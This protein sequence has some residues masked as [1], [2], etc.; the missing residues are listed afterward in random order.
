MAAN[1]PG[2]TTTTAPT[3]GSPQFQQEYMARLVWKNAVLGSLNALAL[4]LAA[5]L[6]VLAATG[7]AIFL[8]WLALGSAGPPDLTRCLAL[9]VYLVGCLVPVVW[10]ASRK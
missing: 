5:R 4:V 1:Q 7:G 10:L 9:G 3:P 6:A 8:A 2:A